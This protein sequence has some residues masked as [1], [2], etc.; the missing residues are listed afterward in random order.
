[1]YRPPAPRVVGCER[2]H[3]GLPP[4]T[5]VT[6][7]FLEQLV[8]RDIS[9]A[10]RL[11]RKQHTEQR[12][13]TARNESL[14]SWSYFHSPSSKVNV[15]PPCSS[16]TL[17]LSILTIRLP[18]ISSPTCSILVVNQGIRTFAT[19]RDCLKFEISQFIHH[20]P[21]AD[22]R[23]RAPGLRWQHLRRQRAGYLRGLCSRIRGRRAVDALALAPVASAAAA[24]TP[25]NSGC[26]RKAK[27]I[28]R[29]HR[30][31]YSQKNQNP[32]SQVTLSASACRPTPDQSIAS[33][34]LSFVG[35]YDGGSSPRRHGLC[36]AC[37]TPQSQCRSGLIPTIFRP[38]TKSPICTFRASTSA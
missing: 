35:L 29:Q 34:Y 36:C 27:G 23:I 6:R 13:T 14:F 10:D 25:F 22:E 12:Q 20:D 30:H 4:Q 32:L 15:R 18:L 31:G 38:S 1:M 33:I 5:T 8:Y 28:E 2:A 7:T 24:L 16:V 17:S 11:L 9:D 19:E 3:V 26:G 37:R 21:V